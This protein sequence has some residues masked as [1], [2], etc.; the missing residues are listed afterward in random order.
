LPF[1]AVSADKAE[2]CLVLAKKIIEGNPN[3][4]HWKLVAINAAFI[5]SKFVEPLPLPEAYQKMEKLIFSGAMTE[6]L[7]EYKRN[8][9]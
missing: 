3:S 2:D 4:E 6:V 9:N 5:Y 1:S 7:N 8:L